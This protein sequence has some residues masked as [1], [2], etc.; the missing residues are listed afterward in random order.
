MKSNLMQSFQLQFFFW[1]WE[2]PTGCQIRG[3][4]WVGDYSHFVFRQ[5]LLGVDVSVTG[6][7]NG[8]AARSI[9]AN[10]RGDD[11]AGFHAVAAKRRR[12]TWNSQFDLLGQILCST[13]TAV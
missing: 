2:E 6:R 8:D 1:K 7:C 9:L 10:V 4:R 3:V 12:I 5:K 13:T 11:F